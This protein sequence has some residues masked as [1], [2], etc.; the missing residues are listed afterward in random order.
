M[1]PNEEYLDQL[2][3]SLTEGNPSAKEGEDDADDGIG[4]L[5][6]QFSDEPHNVPEELISGLMGDS[7]STPDSPDEEMTDILSDE[8]SIDLPGEEPEEMVNAEPELSEVPEMPDTSEEAEME[9]LLDM[10]DVEAVSAIDDGEEL[11]PVADEGEEADMDDLGS[12]LESLG[13]EG[14][15]DV[16]EISELLDKADRDEPIVDMS[17]AEPTEVGGE[18]EEVPSKK[19]KRQKKERIKKERVKK[20][21]KSRRSRKEQ[22]TQEETESPA[23]GTDTGIDELLGSMQQETEETQL[24][25][26]AAEEKKQGFWGKLLNTLTQE[27]EEPEDPADLISDE[28]G[29]IMEQLDKEDQGKGKKKKKADKKKGKGKKSADAEDDEELEEA[30]DTKK[31][32]KKEK[33][34]KAEKAPVAAEDL[35]PGKKLSLKKIL[36]VVLVALVFCAAYVLVSSLY[37]GHVNK[38]RAEEA[39][40][41]GN[42]LECYGLLVGQ[43]MN[44]SQEVIFH[45]SELALQ[46]ERMKGNY[47][48][49]VMAGKELEA[50]D[51]LVQ[52][53]CRRE[54]FYLK[55]QE[56]GCQDIVEQTFTGMEGLL[57]INY[58]LDEIRAREI[59][60]LKSDVDYTIALLNVLEEL[61]SPVSDEESEGQQPSASY[62]DLLPEEEEISDTEFVDTIG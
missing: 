40:Y 42:Y 11:E 16:R 44:E 31:K 52:F 23:E 1:D 26:A 62:D 47:Q 39:Y 7:K 29:A 58:G 43:N 55:G 21:K 37:I 24:E 25:E 51:Y 12:L 18:A 48:R 50:L 5:L 41:A 33:K 54:E 35:L 32:K 38:Q 28:N 4:D 19:R 57:K 61:H 10:G 14:D 13:A 53:V 56:W 46:M 34:P 60:A 2:L 8:I 20:E 9:S 45:K 22:K 49:L 59:A 36:P 15:E 30:P 17:D 27:E 3:R 6:N